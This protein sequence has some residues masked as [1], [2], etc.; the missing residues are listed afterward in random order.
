MTKFIKSALLVGALVGSTAVVSFADAPKTADKTGAGSASGSG[1]AG[2]G[3]AAKGKTTT[4]KKTPP[5]K[6]AG[7]GAATK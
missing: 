3:S 4:T 1:D 2:S 5:A 6:S 7:S